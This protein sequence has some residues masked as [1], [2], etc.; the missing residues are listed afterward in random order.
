MSFQDWFYN[1]RDCSEQYI[2]VYL[3]DPSKLTQD[4]VARQDA[5]A[6]RYIEEAQ[7]LIASL[8][9]YRQALAARYGE[10]AT[11]LYSRR[12]ELVR[13]IRNDHKL[14]WVRLV[15]R[16]EDGTEIKEIQERYTGKERHAALA[17]FSALKKQYP[18]IEAVEDIAKR[19]WER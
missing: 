5:N 14:Y 13:E 2:R 12:L 1:G 11:A 10:L 18:G 17:R 4:E 7:Q 15:L 8:Q 16:Y 6:A 19:S 9:E 3:R